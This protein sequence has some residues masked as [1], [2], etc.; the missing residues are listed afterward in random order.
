MRGAECHR[1]IPSCAAGFLGVPGHNVGAVT[2]DQPTFVM[3]Q[4]SYSVGMCSATRRRSYKGVSL[5]FNVRRLNASEC[6]RE[7]RL[8]LS[9]R[10]ADSADDLWEKTGGNDGMALFGQMDAIGLPMS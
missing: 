8:D 10:F 3:I 9:T 5:R 7:G 2:T 1:T 4:A 6:S